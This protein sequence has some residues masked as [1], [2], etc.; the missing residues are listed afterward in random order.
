MTISPVV[1]VHADDPAID[2]DIVV[3]IKQ[4]HPDLPVVTG[5]TEEE[6]ARIIPEAEIIFGLYL[7]PHLLEQAGKLRW[8]QIMAAGLDSFRDLP[9]L[10]NAVVFTNLRGVL[11]GPVAE[12]ALTYMLAHAQAVPRVLQQQR[13]H[14]WVK[15]TPQQLTGGTVGILGLGANGQAVAKRCAAFGMRVIGL[16]RSPGPVGGVERVYTIDQIEQFLPQ[17]DYLV[18]TLP[19]TPE[20][21]GLLN[22]DRLRLLK[23]GC[24]LINLGRGSLI[25]LDD[26][27]QALDQGWLAGA[28]L[29]VFPEEPLP[30]QHPLWD[31][32]NVFV[33]PHIAGISRPE[34]VVQVFLDNLERYLNGEPLLNQVDLARGY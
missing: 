9:P 28:A 34:A 3:A 15:F 30:A 2:A 31:W 19:N 21:A 20:T 33:T 27:L 25:P 10:P 24:F 14:E 7:P 4:R 12:Y 18:C 8:F 32:E 5:R 29:D 13:R 1:L 22:A 6:L 11:G 16:K 26:L 23:P 17:C